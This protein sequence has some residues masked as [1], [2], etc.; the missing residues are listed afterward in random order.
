M[1]ETN[2]KSKGALLAAMALAVAA[3]V[4]VPAWAAGG[5]QIYVSNERSGDITVIDGASLK[6][7][8]TFA[9]GKR[10]RGV[11]A[12]PDGKVVYVALSGTPIEGPPELDANGNPVFKRDK[13][14]DDDDDVAADKSAD[15]IG[16]VDVATRK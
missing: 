4:A 6:A 11:H 2:R 7:V 13:K 9:V 15:G 14:D 1:S 5:Y 12:S 8:A 3:P 16:V 10:P